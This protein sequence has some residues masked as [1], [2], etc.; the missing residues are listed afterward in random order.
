MTGKKI[1]EVSHY[2]NQINV[3]VLNLSAN[4]KKGDNVHFL[5]HG[6]DFRQEITS[7]QIE[8]ESIETA[9]KGDMVAVKVEKPVRKGTVAYLLTED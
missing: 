9:K 4:L 8:H 1:G 3:A 5:G 7:M 2:F 6:C